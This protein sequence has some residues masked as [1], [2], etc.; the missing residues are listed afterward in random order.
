MKPTDEKMAA[1]WA[2]RRLEHDEKM[3]EILNRL[4]QAFHPFVKDFSWEM[5]HASGFHEVEAFAED[6]VYHLIPAIDNYRRKND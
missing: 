2:A 5:G 4:P 1:L 6:L 3:A